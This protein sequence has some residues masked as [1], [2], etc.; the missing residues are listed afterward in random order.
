MTNILTVSDLRKKTP[1]QLEAL[2]VQL[3]EQLRAAQFEVRT[4]QLKKVHEVQRLRRSVAKVMTI[5][6]QQIREQK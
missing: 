1:A 5:K 6:N 2:K 3:Q 4:G